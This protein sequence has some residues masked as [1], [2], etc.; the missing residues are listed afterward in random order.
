[1]DST[2]FYFINFFIELFYQRLDF[3][4]VFSFRIWKARS[5]E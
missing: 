2:K 3:L 4:V 1:M 5:N